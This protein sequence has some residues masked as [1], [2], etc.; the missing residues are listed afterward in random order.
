[1]TGWSGSALCS[2]SWCCLGFPWSTCSPLARP[3]GDQTARERPPQEVPGCP[4]TV[5]GAVAPTLDARGLPGSMGYPKHRGASCTCLRT[6]TQQRVAGRESAGRGCGWPPAGRGCTR[7][8]CPR[9]RDLARLLPRQE[10]GKVLQTVR[11]TGR[12]VHATPCGGQS[13]MLPGNLLLIEGV[14]PQTAQGPG[15]AE[16]LGESYGRRDH[17]VLEAVIDK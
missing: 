11:G 2:Q 15:T 16:S 17:T 13:L 12:C 7:H 4:P 9:V 5:R 1:M 6:C 14:N 8:L 3:P 10:E